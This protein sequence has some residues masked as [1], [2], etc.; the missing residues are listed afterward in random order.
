M[1]F[2]LAAQAPRFGLEFAR[3]ST[4]SDT[5]IGQLSCVSA[6]LAPMFYRRVV[7]YLNQLSEPDG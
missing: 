2:E 7:S 5:E 3:S 4:Y 6:S 1:C